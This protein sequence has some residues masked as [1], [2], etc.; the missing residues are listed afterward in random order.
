MG[1][2][3]T[4]EKDGETMVPEQFTLLAYSGDECRGVAKWVDSLAFLTIY[5]QGSEPISYRAI[6]QTDGTVYAVEQQAT[7]AQTVVGTTQK[8]VVLTLTDASNEPTAIDLATGNTTGH[9]HITG[10]YT[11]SGTLVTRRA[12][13]LPT[14]VY[15][16]RYSDGSFRKVKK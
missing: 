2:I 5:G 13:Q 8:P 4:I 1:V 16:V 7:F 14:G 6:D 10:Y 15:I 12:S 3:A 11:L 9:G